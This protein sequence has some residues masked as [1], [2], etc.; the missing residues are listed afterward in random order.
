MGF[1]RSDDYQP[2]GYFRGHAVYVTGLLV[3]MHVAAWVAFA[4][5]QAFGLGWVASFLD[6]NSEAVFLHGQVWRLVTYAFWH[7]TG[8]GD[9]IWL[10]VELAMFYVFGREVEKYLGRRVFLAIYGALLVTTPVVLA[11]W[12][13]GMHLALPAA[14]SS[15]LHFGIF[16]AF[17][18]IYPNVQL[19]FGI[20]AKWLAFILLGIFTLV[21]LS[22]HNWP[23]ISVMWANVG[24]AFYAT[25]FAGVGESVSILGSLR[26]HLP[27]RTPPRG[28]KPRLKPRRMVES[29]GG[30]SDVHESIDPLLDKISKHGLASLSTSERALLERARVSLLRKERGN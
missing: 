25:R 10:A 23:G 2:L 5:L 6:F 18:A 15:A 19:F 1:D 11:A 16:I 14:G 17:V 9:S 21:D 24:V 4:L 30:A 26:D 13:A 29:G 22:E 20:A 12:M 28:V 7:R 8:L 27:M 3:T